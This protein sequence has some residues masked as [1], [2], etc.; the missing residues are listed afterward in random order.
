MRLAPTAKPSP[1]RSRP[2]RKRTSTEP[3]APA[4]IR[5]AVRPEERARRAG[6]PIDRAL[7]TCACG[8]AFD[9]PVTASV[10][11]PRCGDAQAW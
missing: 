5:S 11:C 9:A 3:F 1:G 6:G 4:R 7:Y 8:H 2:P 10:R